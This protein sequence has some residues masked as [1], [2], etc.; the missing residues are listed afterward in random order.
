MSEPWNLTEAQRRQFREAQAEAKRTKP[1]SKPWRVTWPSLVN[2]DPHSEDY[3]SQRAAYEAVESITRIRVK[4]TV[5]H[6]E[7]GDWRLHER[8]EPEA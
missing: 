5:W 1:P 2:R 8:I 3:R 7:N 6:W 4:A